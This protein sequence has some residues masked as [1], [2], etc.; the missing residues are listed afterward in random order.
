MSVE[1]AAVAA[2]RGVL[3]IRITNREEAAAFLDYVESRSDV[4]ITRAYPPLAPATGPTAAA[5]F[6]LAVVASL[7]EE[8]M[9]MEV[10]LL[11]RAWEA[12]RS[13]EGK[14]P[15]AELVERP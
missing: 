11:L 13:A 5:E 1:S 12:A 3:R 7:N 4:I 6:E 9:R 2:R 8:A 10:V 14:Q 15:T